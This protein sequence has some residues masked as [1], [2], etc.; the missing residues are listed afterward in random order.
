MMNS[1][2][3]NA[4]NNLSSCVEFRSKK[5]IA[6]AGN[7]DGEKTWNNLDQNVLRKIFLAG[8]FTTAMPASCVC[9]YWRDVGKPIARELNPIKGRIMKQLGMARKLARKNS[10]YSYYDD[11]S[12]SDEEDVVEEIDEAKVKRERESVRKFVID[13]EEEITQKRLDN[14][15]LLREGEAQRHCK[16]RYQRRRYGGHYNLFNIRNSVARLLLPPVYS[17][18][19]K[20]P[21]KKLLD[22]NWGLWDFAARLFHREERTGMNK[23]LRVYVSRQMVYRRRALMVGFEQLSI[24][25]R[26][27]DSAKY[28][29]VREFIEYGEGHVLGARRKK[30]TV[31]VQNVLES[32]FN[33]YNQGQGEARMAESVLRFNEVKATVL[34]ELKSFEDDKELGQKAFK[35]HFVPKEKKK[36]AATKK[37][38]TT[39]KEKMAAK[40]VSKKK[41]G[42]AAK[43]GSFFSE[44]N[45]TTDFNESCALEA[46]AVRDLK[47]KRAKKR[48]IKDEDNALE[49]EGD[50]GDGEKQEEK[51][52][53]LPRPV[54]K[55]M[56]TKEEKVVEKD[57]N[58]RIFGKMIKKEKAL[59]SEAL[60]LP[61][62]VSAPDAK[63]TT[64]PE[65]R[66]SSRARKPST[67]AAAAAVAAATEMKATGKGKKRCN[68]M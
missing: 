18:G 19:G 37:A 44:K 6:I 52:E 33:V 26:F 31:R 36:T 4:R 63:P 38:K 32:M 61:V 62:V 67:K 7:V 51:R 24:P 2:K 3:N 47:L 11:S 56:K 39:K 34:R 53:E 21:T 12:S 22:D 8:G 42:T 40:V 17:D 30:R 27:L 29:K 28:R 57:S 20:I 25:A 59:G 15:L 65:T 66:R 55:K 35:M 23:L 14:A 64:L 45:S 9:K 50:E 13:K 10:Y 68:L 43:D 49:F 46:S 5:E 58:P 48:P 41:S 54:A 1:N 16:F 60:P